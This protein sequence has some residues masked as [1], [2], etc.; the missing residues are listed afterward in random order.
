MF[1]DWL[2]IYQDH[3]QSLPI[4][5]DQYMVVYDTDTGEAVTERQPAFSHEGSYSTSIR[6]RVS[7]QRVTVSGNPSR[8]GR[9]EN[10]FGFTR[11]DDCVA[12]YNRILAQY[13]LPPFSKNKQLLTTSGVNGDRRK[14]G[15]GGA[16]ITE[17]HVTSNL[18]VGAGNVD[19]F[20]R[21]LSTQ[22]YR[23]SVP[24]LHLNGK[25]V[26]WLSGTTGRASELMYVSAYAK[27]FELELHALPKIKRLFGE[28]SSEYRYLSGVIDYC[29]DQGIVRFESK[30][31]SRFL[32]RAELSFY[33]C[34]D[35][36]K[37]SNVHEE[38]L[39][40]PERLRVEALDFENISE[41]LISS[42]VVSSTHAANCT[43]MYALQWMHGA[44]F[45]FSSSR[46]RTHRARLRKIGI[47]IKL[48]CDLS[49]FSLVRVKKARSVEIRP[50]DMPAWYKPPRALRLVA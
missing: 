39:R 23:H 16:I 6:I 1:I 43:A 34:V 29:N 28:E 9:L 32:R 30:L 3:D 38:F 42:G 44:K 19:D 10:L 40:V 46:V 48:P 49:K 26:D 11:L 22:P 37:I 33:G 13:G 50:V 24:R 25:T 5:S 35:M 17:L 12:V 7:G 4:V 41:Q 8:F 21:A 20:L 27:G 2:T 18:S 15:D 14:I 31:K 47:D 45:D 36:E